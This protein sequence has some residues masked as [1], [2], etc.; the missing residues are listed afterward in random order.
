MSLA[1]SGKFD[2]GQLPRIAG[3]PVTVT[4]ARTV[5]PGFEGRYL[6]WTED[7]VA[8]L[9]TVHGCLGAGVL[10]PGPDGGEHQIVFRFIDGLSL[11]QW[12]RSPQREALM[13]E[14]AAFVLSE[15]IQRTVGID[16]WFELPTRA[17]PK[18]PLWGRILTDVAWVFPV[19]TA[20]SLLVSPM[21]GAWPFL[22]RASLSTLLITSAMRIAVG[23]FRSRLRA[24]RTM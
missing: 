10:H 16:N 8:A 21:L 2:T 3:V 13:A 5:A 24:R 23:P 7:V 15:R 19:A 1:L 14:A 11:R 22:L 4:V 9:R 17:E 6:Q 12:E 20:F 18:R